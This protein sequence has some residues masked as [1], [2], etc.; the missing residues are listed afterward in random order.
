MRFNFKNVLDTRTCHSSEAAVLIF[1]SQKIQEISYLLQ[2]MTFLNFSDIDL[3]Q[4]LCLSILEWMHIYISR[5][6]DKLNIIFHRCTK[7]TG[8]FRLFLICANFEFSL[9]SHY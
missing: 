8:L 7:T 2:F 3:A 6:T 4:R 9:K 5:E 1:M